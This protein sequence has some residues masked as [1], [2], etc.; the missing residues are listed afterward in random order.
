MGFFSKLFGKKD[1]PAA[2]AFAQ[3]GQSLDESGFVRMFE[4]SPSFS[5]VAFPGDMRS[6]LPGF[7]SECHYEL[8]RTGSFSGPF[9]DLYEGLRQPTGP[10]NTIVQKAWFQGAGHTILLDPEMVLIVTA[11]DELSKMSAK[12]RGKVKAAIWERGSETVALAEIGAEGVIRRHGIAK[13]KRPKKRLSAEA[14]MPKSLRDLTAM[15]LEP[16]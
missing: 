6:E 12:A 16:H 14:V 5:F 2:D 1:E 11:I 13:E 8:L 10:G 4:R 3:A 15:D 9:E 7:L